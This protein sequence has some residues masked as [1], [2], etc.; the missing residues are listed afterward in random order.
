MHTVVETQGFFRQSQK[1]GMTDEELDAI[2]R[3]VSQNPS[4]GNVIPGTGGARK[5][6]IP[7]RGK[8]KSGSYRIVTFYSGVN[9][10]VFLLDVYAKSSKENLT[11]AERNSIKASLSSI[12]EEYRE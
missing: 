2:R 3:V 10:S 6:R 1:L 7:V 5:V 11:R 4:V 12:L 9:Y 8:G